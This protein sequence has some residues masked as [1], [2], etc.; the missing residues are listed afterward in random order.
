MEQQY[1]L[2]TDPLLVLMAAECEDVQDEL[3][4]EAE[5]DLRESQLMAAQFI[6]KRNS[7]V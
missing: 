3:E 1:T 6:V 7:D 5:C 4:F 2:Q